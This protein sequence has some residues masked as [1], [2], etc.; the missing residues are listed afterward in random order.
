M[1]ST[2]EKLL[3]LVKVELTDNGVI[4]AADAFELLLAL[5]VMLLLLLFADAI[6]VIDFCFK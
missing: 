4:V 6:D 1:L 2:P 3:R 5:F